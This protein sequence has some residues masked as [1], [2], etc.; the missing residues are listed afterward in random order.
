MGVLSELPVAGA[1][2]W[3]DGAR[4]FIGR[5][6][7]RRLVA[8]GA[9]VLTYDGDVRDRGAVATSLRDAAPDAALHLA[10]QV[11]V[12]RDP[13]L[14]RVMEAVIL[15]GA[16]AVLDGVAAL[17]RPC[18]MV[19][20]GTCEEYGTIEAPFAEDDAPSAPVSPYS[21]WKLA[22]TREALARAGE[23]DVVVVRPFLSYGAGQRPRMLVPAAIAA[24]RRR[25][26]FLTTEG[27]QTR[28]WNHVDDTVE[29]LIR[30]AFVFDPAHRLYNLGGGPELPVR[31]VVDRIF[32]LVGAPR[33][34]VRRG[35]LSTRA[36]EVP[37]F[38]CDPRRAAVDLG[39]TARVG[40]T[41][42]LQHTLGGTP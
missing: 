37:R 11:D 16:R 42:G 30:A 12:A 17:P 9:E 2:V 40:L 36:G 5:H 14:N 31:D 29:G 39:H 23:V 35:A 25:E 41:E 13:S 4:G 18:R 10:A 1:R 19:Q 33:S 38:V 3:L 32:D 26:P 34:L 7:L 15:G 28:E 20:V 21:R 6:L 8:L 24:A 27:T 22:A